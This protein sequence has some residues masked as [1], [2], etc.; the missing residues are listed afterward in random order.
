MPQDGPCSIRGIE[1]A[2]TPR[3]CSAR[4]KKIDLFQNS[5][6]YASLRQE[7]PKIA[8][9]ISSR[10]RQQLT[11]SWCPSGRG[12]IFLL[13]VAPQYLL[14]PISG[15]EAGSNFVSIMPILAIQALDGGISSTDTVTR[16][17]TPSTSPTRSHPYLEYDHRLK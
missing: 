14:H 13:D 8:L 16:S 7:H 12:F 4:P 1:G 15:L 5:S 11:L 10:Y 6:I 3:A 9:E 2:D 17:L